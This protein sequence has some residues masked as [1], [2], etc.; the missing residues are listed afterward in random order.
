MQ[1]AKKII[2]VIRMYKNIFTTKSGTNG[3]TISRI[4]LNKLRTVPV[5]GLKR[6]LKY[7][8]CLATIILHLRAFCGTNIV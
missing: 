1:Y 6:I 3:F 5:N 7:V 8:R 4:E 2:F